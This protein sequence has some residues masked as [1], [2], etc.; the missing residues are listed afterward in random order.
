MVRMI[1]WRSALVILLLS[2]GAAA[3]ADAQ[4]LTTILSFDGADGSQPN[5][6]LV[7]GF[8]GN[9]YGT[10]MTG[11][12][13]GYGTV[14]QV[15][16]AGTLATLHSFDGSDGTWP[17]SA[18]AQSPDGSFYGSAVFGGNT[19]ACEPSGCG[20]LFKITPGGALTRLYAFR[21]VDQSNC[22]NGAFPESAPIQA[23]GGNIYG[24]T[25]QG[26]FNCN[27]YRGCGTVYKITP[28]GGLTTL[29][30]FCELKGNCVDGLY[31][32][33]PLTQDTDGTLY[34][35]TFGGGTTGNLCN[36]ST[37]CGTLFKI[38]TQAKLT[39]LHTFAGP[40][41]ANPSGPLILASD[42][43]LYG[44]AGEGG[45]YNCGTIFRISQK[46]EFRTIYSF[47]C[48]PNDGGRPLSLFEAGDGNFYG[49]TESGGSTS[50]DGTVFR[51]TPQGN[52]T[53]LYRF[54]ELA[55][56]PD[57]A[58][59]CG[60]GQAT[61]GL[62]YGVTNFGGNTNDGTV[63]SLDVGLAPFVEALPGYGHAG[64]VIV[65]LGNDL[66]GATR[67]RFNGIDAVFTVVSDTEIKASVPQGATT[68]KI[69]VATPAL[70]LKS[71]FVFLVK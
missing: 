18:L 13:D 58:V 3:S 37:G 57:G 25:S 24:A 28:Q 59:P 48:G 60:I 43:N 17:V 51:V 71:N 8:D 21:C 70:V 10:T 62:L 31:P 2:A 69:A 22:N 11:G 32:Q 7:Q 29:Y 20:T 66:T 53:V 54:C 12:V 50:D 6:S 67:V 14:F 49:T 33:S 52:E 61:N 68:G 63:F 55:G 16:P 45:P 44:T 41:G 64:E 38:T 46:G 47:R 26:G 39:T 19:S 40:D 23:A 27:N 5:G 35:S 15:T 42:G 9:L 56:C 4:T 36:G 65:I 1:V 30:L 34:G